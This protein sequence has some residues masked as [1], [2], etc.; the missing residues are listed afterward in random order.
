M[1]PMLMLRP[2]LPQPLSTGNWFLLETKEGKLHPYILTTQ[3][4][5]HHYTSTIMEFKSI[6][7]LFTA[8]LKQGG[9]A[10]RPM[11]HGCLVCVVGW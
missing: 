11:V 2:Y 9:F 6:W 4:L 3:K 7:K 10:I 1:A 8:R 5:T